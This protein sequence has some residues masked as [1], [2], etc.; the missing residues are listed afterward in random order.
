MILAR[1][2]ADIFE[3]LIARTQKKQGKLGL[4]LQAFDNK[5]AQ[6]NKEISTKYPQNIKAVNLTKFSAGGV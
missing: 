1:G 4:I 6:Q 3:G 5:I 2:E